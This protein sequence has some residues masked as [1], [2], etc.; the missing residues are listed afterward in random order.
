MS[1]AQAVV[2]RLEAV[3]VGQLTWMKPWVGVI[4]GGNADYGGL[5]G[6]GALLPFPRVGIDASTGT[7]EFELGPAL[8]P[9]GDGRV[10]IPSS[11]RY[12]GIHLAASEPLP[13]ST[14]PPLP[15]VYGV[16]PGSLAEKASLAAGD[17]ILAV[18]GVPGLGPLASLIHRLW[19]PDG[20]TVRVDL[21]RPSGETK[22]IVIP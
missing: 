6:A 16:D 4:L 2:V 9:G 12:L 11:G 19:A 14:V 21:R 13:G 15:V 18:D 7:V 1:A 8:R 17:M 20:T 5:L 22:T 10:M 3:T